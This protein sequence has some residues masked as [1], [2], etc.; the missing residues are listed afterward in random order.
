[1]RHLMT[2]L[3]ML[4]LSSGTHAADESLPTKLLDVTIEH[5]STCGPD[6]DAAQFIATE[7]RSWEQ[8]EAL[9]QATLPYL[10][11]QSPQKV[12][13][14]LAVLYRLR[15]Y[16]PIHD[17]IG[18]QGSAWELKNRPVEFWSQLDN[19]VYSH[20]DYFHALN[21]SAVFHNLSLYLG[22]SPSGESRREL[23]RIAEETPEK[24]QALIC[25]GW[26]D[27]IEK[28]VQQMKEHGIVEQG[29]SD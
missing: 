8:H 10:T 14:A 24:E 11:N 26:L 20:F 16:R 6:E 15:G 17:L 19:A 25:L 9:A 21:N 4:S 7:Q 27:E 22:V 3:A 23:H 1:M 13:G 12:A 18:S 5:I 29:R 28:H 2:L